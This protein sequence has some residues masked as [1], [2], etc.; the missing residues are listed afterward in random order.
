MNTPTRPRLPLHWK[1]GI[2]F[3]TGLAAGLI[4]YYSVGGGA[5]WC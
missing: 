1:I 4:V 3:A 5:G 2:G